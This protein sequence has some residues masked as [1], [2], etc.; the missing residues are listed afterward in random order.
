MRRGLPLVLALG[1]TLGAVGCGKSYYAAYREANPEWLPVFPDPDATLE[2]TLAS[3][4]APPKPDN[5]ISV[6]RLEILRVD[7]EPWQEVS[8]E[9]LRDGT[10]S[11]ED[12]HS[13]LVVADLVCRASYDLRVF[14]GQKVAWYLLP[15]NRL[16][17]YDHYEF[18]EAC[19]A[20]GDF[21]RAG[22]ADAAS[23]ALE[24]E[25]AAHLEAA[26]P[27]SMFHVVHLVGQ[28]VAL[29]RA[30]RLEEAETLLTAGRGALDVSSG[31]APR[32]EEP[33]VRIEVQDPA[34]ARQGL[35]RL[36]NAI[37]EERRSAREE[38][39]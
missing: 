27:P 32:F 13:Y 14:Q 6:R 29:A 34:A 25:A 33:G 3:L 15:E 21:Q 9:A 19:T 30:G 38:G 23:R 7:V 26:Y 1:L 18:V 8:F 17:S 2:V 24:E 22:D 39:R 16:G 11:S 12:D 10:F 37:E 20:W 35:E 31:E 28:G 4:Y 5:R 36:V